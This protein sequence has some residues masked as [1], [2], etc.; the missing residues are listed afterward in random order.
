MSIAL[1]SHISYL[2]EPPFKTKVHVQTI[3]SKPVNSKMQI[4]HRYHLLFFNPA[5]LAS[6]SAFVKAPIFSRKA[7]SE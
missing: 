7:S 6:S 3:L 1:G 2:S 5:G 4:H